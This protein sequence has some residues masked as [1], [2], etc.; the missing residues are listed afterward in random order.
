V[1]RDGRF[2]VGN[3]AGEVHALVGEGITLALRGAA[4]LADTVAALGVGAAAGAAYERA[5][6]REF[7][8]RYHAANVFAHVAMRPGVAGVVAGLLDRQPELMRACVAS[9]G[10]W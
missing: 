8:L 5:W 1:Y 6:R 10:K 3:A 9:T 7:A 2:F 4:I